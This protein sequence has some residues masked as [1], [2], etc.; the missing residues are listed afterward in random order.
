MLTKPG[1]TTASGVVRLKK[2]STAGAIAELTES[3]LR[4]TPGRRDPGRRDPGQTNSD[5]RGPGWRDPGRKDPSRPFIL[6]GWQ[7]VS[8][9]GIPS[10]HQLC[11]E[12]F[13]WT[14]NC[15]RY[16]YPAR[17]EFILS[18]ETDEK[19]IGNESAVAPSVLLGIHLSPRVCEI[20]AR[21]HMYV[22]GLCW[23]NV[24]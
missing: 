15:L 17:G 5:L 12:Y 11:P 14:R 6:A 7:H 8:G 24:Q 18:G 3:R 2:T 9:W 21:W 23:Y 10:L 19:H 20:Q 22:L 16:Q 1:S 13:L 4:S